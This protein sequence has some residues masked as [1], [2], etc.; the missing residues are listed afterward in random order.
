MVLLSAAVTLGAALVFTTR[1]VLLVLVVAPPDEEEL[2]CGCA[3]IMDDDGRGLLPPTDIRA[4]WEEVTSEDM[5]SWLD[6][7]PLPI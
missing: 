2:N 4:K 1:D 6:R 7:W 3:L 5:V